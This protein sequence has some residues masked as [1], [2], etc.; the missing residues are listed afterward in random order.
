MDTARRCV[1]PDV[2]FSKGRN[3]ERRA[4]ELIQDARRTVRLASDIPLSPKEQ[5][6]ERQLKETQEMD[7]FVYQDIQ[8]QGN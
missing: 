3:D 8:I 2:W 1:I 4:G 5:A 6:E 7:M